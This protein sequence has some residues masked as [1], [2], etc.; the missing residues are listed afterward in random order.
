[1]KRR[2]P[3][4]ACGLVASAALTACS[5]FDTSRVAT[6]N[7]EQIDKAVIE[8]LNA[9]G[10]GDAPPEGNVK[11]LNGPSLRNSVG[12]MVQALLAEQIAA[13]F[14][15][16]LTEA[17]KGSLE[18]LQQGL[19]GERLRRWNELSEEERDLVIDFRAAPLAMINT[20]GPAPVDL[21]QRYANPER[22]G[23]FCI[24]FIAFE[25]AELADIAFA[26]LKKGTDFGT[27]ANS[28]EPQSNGGIV[29][30]PDGGEC[31][32]IE[33]F[34]PPTTPIELAEALFNGV[35][36]EVIAPVRVSSDNG[37]AWFILL[38]RPWEEIGSILTQAVEASPSY[39]EYQ[40]QLSVASV[41]V[42]NRYG[43]WDPVS[44]N[45]VTSK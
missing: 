36:G 17:R 19:S 16:D 31:V 42:A 45:V 43:K 14:G 8:M 18:S 27:L 25:S 7:G 10:E 40:A 3:I 21:Q 37:V 20:P 34:R 33:N 28:L 35:P 24:R 39:A 30:G 32:N 6:V 29:A 23:Y 2:I 1:M 4:L 38:H 5:T 15:I 9:P 26:E 41:R 11:A 44:A 13:Q 12:N 22:T